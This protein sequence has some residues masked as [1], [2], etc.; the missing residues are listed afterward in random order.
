MPRILEL[1]GV[2]RPLPV[3]WVRQSESF[4][5]EA[6]YRA[7]LPAHSYAHVVRVAMLEGSVKRIVELSTII[8]VG[9]LRKL[10]D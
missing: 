2:S 5:K 1:Y 9:R 4:A 7:D 8:S 3:W 10:A 6:I